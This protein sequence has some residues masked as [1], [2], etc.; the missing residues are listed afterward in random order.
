L[1]FLRAQLE[2]DSLLCAW[3]KVHPLEALQ[4]PHGT[5]RAAG[6]LVNVELD[7]GIAGAVA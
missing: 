7:H 3:G 1:Q 6:T 2:L 4:L 5:R